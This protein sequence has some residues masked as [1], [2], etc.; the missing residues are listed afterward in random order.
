MQ[1]KQDYHECLLCAGLRL[2]LI[3]AV[4]RAC[5]AGVLFCC[6]ICTA[7]CTYVLGCSFTGVAAFYVLRPSPEL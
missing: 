3:C 5:N 6:C 7:N 4:L 2:L 1:G